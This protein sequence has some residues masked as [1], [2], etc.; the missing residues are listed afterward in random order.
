MT[1]RRPSRRDPELTGRR[2]FQAATPD[3]LAGR[4]GTLLQKTDRYALR[5]NLRGL[6]NHARLMARNSDPMRSYLMM[7]RRHVVGHRGIRLL[8]DV[9]R[10]GDG[11]SDRR[12]N[13]LIEDAWTRW[14]RRGVPTRCGSLSLWQLE[15]MVATMLGLEGNFFARVFSRGDF[16]MQLQPLTLDL[17]DLDTTR[18]ITGGWIEAG[19]EYRASDDSVAAYHFWT[20]PPSEVHRGRVREKVRIPAEQIIHVFRCHTS[21]QALGVPGVPAGLRTLNMLQGFEEAALTAAKYGAMN[22]LFFFEREDD[23]E[24]RADDVDDTIPIDRMEA[25]TVALLPPG[26]EPSNY[27]PT[28]PDADLPGFTKHFLRKFASGAGVSYAGLTADMEGANFSSLRDGRNEERDEW[29]MFQ[30]D[31]VEGFH[32]PVF[33]K[34]LMPAMM[35]RQLGLPLSHFDKFNAPTWRGRGWASVNPKDDAQAVEIEL[36][37]RT[38]SLSEVVAERGG[39]LREVLARIRADRELFEEFG[40]N[41]DLPPPPAPPAPPPDKRNPDTGEEE[42]GDVRG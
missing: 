15:C 13:A 34:W 7:V 42:A 22:M 5:W 36:R 33:R 31:L 26:V 12:A 18:E 19:I 29:R 37:H 6:V 1:I 25:G 30:Q 21:G 2:D 14:G 9:K 38:K 8:M 23:D 39:D 28:Y 20:T 16:G 3:R 35:S 4:F 17:L 27:S 24:P 11:S 40:L 32:G 10:A 41:P